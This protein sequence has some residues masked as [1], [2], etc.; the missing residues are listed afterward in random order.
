MKNR[1]LLL[2]MVAVVDRGME[3]VVL[4][5]LVAAEEVQA[6]EVVMEL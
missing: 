5:V 2:A 3:V 4:E 1:I 6:A